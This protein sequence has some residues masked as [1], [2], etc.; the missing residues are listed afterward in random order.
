MR[1]E[2]LCFQ[3]LLAIVSTGESENTTPIL[4]LAAVV[5]DGVLISRNSV[6]QEMKH[7]YVRE[8][9][10]RRQ[11]NRKQRLGSQRRAAAPLTPVAPPRPWPRTDSGCVR[12]QHVVDRHF[13]VCFAIGAKLRDAKVWERAR[14]RPFGNREGVG[15]NLGQSL[16]CDSQARPDR[17]AARQ[18]RPRSGCLKMNSVRTRSTTAAQDTE[19]RSASG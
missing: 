14:H 19:S 6:L 15:H 9:K 12:V 18:R 4:P 3:W 10:Q 5:S 7:C 2:T 16:S 1:I 11:Q 13:G 8:L 17:G